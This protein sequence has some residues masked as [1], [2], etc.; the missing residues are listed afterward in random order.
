V[1]QSLIVRKSLQNVNLTL[2]DLLMN[3]WRK[4]VFLTAVDKTFGNTLNN[5][6]G[7]LR[8]LIPYLNLRL[9]VL[10]LNHLS[11]DNLLFYAALE[12]MNPYWLERKYNPKRRCY[13]EIRNSAQSTAE[14]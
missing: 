10:D 13:C 12:S 9:N 4:L 7:S 14:E 11:L 2:L 5:H 1:T 3:L 8:T 6:Q